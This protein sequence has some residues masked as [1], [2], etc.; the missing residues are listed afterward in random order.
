MLFNGNLMTDCPIRQHIR[1]FYRI[2]EDI[3]VDYILPHAEVSMR[4][5]TRAW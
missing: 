1:D 3:A 5:K 4:A 2:D